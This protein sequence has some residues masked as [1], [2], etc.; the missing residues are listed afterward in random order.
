MVFEIL[1][2]AISPNGNY[3]IPKTA[4]GPFN[5]YFPIFS[6]FFKMTKKV[7]SKNILITK[8]WRQWSIK[9]PVSY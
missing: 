5:A 3:I 9:H 8:K 1:K 7:K 2:G 4:L 6:S